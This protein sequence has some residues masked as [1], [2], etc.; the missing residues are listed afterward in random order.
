MSQP[1]RAVISSTYLDS[2]DNEL[3]VK[4]VDCL[5]GPLVLM[6]QVDQ[7]QH[8]FH[9]GV[10]GLLLEKYSHTKQREGCE[11]NLIWNVNLLKSKQM[12]RFQTFNSF[13]IFNNWEL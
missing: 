6:P 10:G 8:V 3:S 1:S 13:Q 4:Q 11:I 5:V 9:L 12:Q 2:S 7:M